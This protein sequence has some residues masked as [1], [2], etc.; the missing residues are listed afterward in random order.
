MLKVL[1]IDADTTF[2]TLLGRA[3]VKEG[4]ETRIVGDATYGVVRARAFEPNLVLMDTAIP[5][6]AGTALIEEIKPLVPGR[7]VV[8]ANSDNVENI[9]AA[10]A[11]GAS[12]YVLKNSGPDAIIARVC[13]AKAS[14]GADDKPDS[15]E[16]GDDGDDG[17][18]M[19]ANAAPKK[20]TR[21]ELRAPVKEG[22]RPF[23]VVIAHPDIEKRAFITEI[24]ERL[25]TAVH[26]IEVAN[27]KDAVTACSENRTVILIID[28]EMPDIPTKQVM[29]TIKDSPGGK[30]TALFVT[31]RG[32]SPEK[33][34]VAMFAGAMA[35][36]GEPWD[37]GSLEAQIKH[38]LD[39]IR[40]RRRKA[41][42]Q[43]L[44]AQAS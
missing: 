11:A 21:R 39:V 31:Y 10:I 14:T 23:C 4:H 12:D 15:T 1:V 36:A 37:D 42:I 26:V 43:A 7:I 24:V 41:K 30:A 6:V 32:N 18:E 5:G 3:L 19:Q 25:N 29:R 44:K 40:K 28:W 34:R 22:K 17:D 33:Q 20:A 38:T 2:S 35:F 27:S 9:R 8:C 13:P 16:S